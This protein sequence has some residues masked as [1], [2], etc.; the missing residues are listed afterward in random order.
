MI[1]FS[2]VVDK[3]VMNT[4]NGNCDRKKRTL[5]IFCN[6]NVNQRFHAIRTCQKSIVNGTL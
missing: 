4:F 5:N 1:K 2:T 6:E 3:C